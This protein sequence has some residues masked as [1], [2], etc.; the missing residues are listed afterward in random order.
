MPGAV[1]LTCNFKCILVKNFHDLNFNDWSIIVPPRIAA[2]TLDCGF[3]RE[4]VYS[5]HNGMIC[6]KPSSSS[7]RVSVVHPSWYPVPNNA[8]SQTLVNPIVSVRNVFPQTVSRY[9]DTKSVTSCFFH[10]CQ[11]TFGHGLFRFFL[12]LFF[13]LSSRIVHATP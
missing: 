2:K 9:C 7:S 12:F 1:S 3:T 4:S 8:S 6:P 11:Y 13:L 10:T 5:P